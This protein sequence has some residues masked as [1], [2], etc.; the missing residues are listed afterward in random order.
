MKRIFFVLT[1]VIFFLHSA[2]ICSAYEK[3]PDF[4]LP[5]IKGGGQ[6]TLSGLKGKV[7]LLIVW[8]TWCSVCRNQLPEMLSIKRD[9]EPKGFEILAVSIDDKP[10]FVSRYI[11]AFE[12]KYGNLNFPVLFDRDK[13]ISKDYMTNGVPNNFIIDRDGNL[14]KVIRGGFPSSKIDSLREM[15]IEVF[16]KSPKTSDILIKKDDYDSFKKSKPDTAKILKVEANRFIVSGGIV[17]KNLLAHTFNMISFKIY[18]CYKTEKEKNSLPKGSVLV[19]F[20][21]GENGKVT[22]STIEQSY[23]NSEKT[24]SCIRTIINKLTFPPPKGGASTVRYPFDFE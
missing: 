15:L 18:D 5:D 24:E 1:A 16:E 22:E 14:V 8:A 4:S 6:Y 23:I 13:R 2:Y 10:E 20:T 17:D 12:S 21:I 3:A 19:R 11:I 9:F 7:V